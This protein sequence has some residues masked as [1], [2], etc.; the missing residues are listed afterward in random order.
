[1]AFLPAL[2]SFS[3]CDKH[4]EQSHRGEERRGEE[5][6]GEERRG[7]ERRGEERRRVFD[8]FFQVYSIIEGIQGRN[9]SRDLKACLIAIPHS[10]TSDQGIHSQPRKCSRNY[11]GTFFAAFQLVFF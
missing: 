3:C 11:G 9:S 4:H 1:L 8:L 5:R 2:V 6:R 10:V 7:E